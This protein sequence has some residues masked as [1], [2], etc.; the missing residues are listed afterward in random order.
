MQPENVSSEDNGVTLLSKNQQKKIAK[1]AKWEATK[2]EFKAKQ[3]EKKKANLKRK[4]EDE[5][6]A[7]IAQGL[8]E[9]EPTPEFKHSHL[10]KDEFLAGCAE[11]FSMLVDCNWDDL[12]SERSLASL[13]QQLMFS[14]G[15]NRR[16]EK[17]SQ[18]YITGV[19]DKLQQKLSKNNCQG[20]LGVS[21]SNDEFVFPSA[22]ASEAVISSSST[23]RSG[24]S[25]N[26]E[27][28]SVATCAKTP[29]YLTSEAEETLED[30][31]PAHVYI[32]GGIVDRNA[33]KGVAF[34]KAKK[35]GMRM[36]KLP[37][38]EHFPY[39][40]TVLTINHVVE[41]LLKF[42]ETKCWKQAIQS[43]IPERKQQ[44]NGEV[45]SALQ[46]TADTDSS[47]KPIVAICGRR[48]RQRVEASESSSGDASA[49]ADA[50]QQTETN[51]VI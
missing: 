12:H 32:I 4:K 50:E 20:W 7:R 37:I 9:E 48:K 42:N 31:D 16:A 30:L 36:A 33:H 11:N 35:L 39:I 26:S 24:D 41:I 21:I 43:I 49:S 5:R 23:L 25:T 15:R 18:L 45:T 29:I 28:A 8:P 14:Y 22:A 6:E 38:K 44:F 2:V 46:T 10:P 1:A 17:P 40:L 51:P 19:S 47:G 27:S 13:S 3:K 34:E